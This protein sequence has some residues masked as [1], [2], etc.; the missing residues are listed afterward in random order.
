LL[1]N[2]TNKLASYEVQ[3]A[4]KLFIIDGSGCLYWPDQSLLIFSDTHFEKGSYLAK[5]GNPLP[6]YDTHDTLTRMQKLIETYQPNK[7][8]CLGD[9]MH[10]AYALERI[11][12]SDFQLLEK[13]CCSVSEWEWIIG[14]H[15]KGDHTQSALKD[16]QFSQELLIDGVI[17]SHHHIENVSYQI[18][19]HYHPKITVKIK[20]SRVSDKCLIITPSKIIMPSFGTYTG[21]LD[22]HH[23]ALQDVIADEPAKYFLIHKKNVW[24]VK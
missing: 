1:N 6:L 20:E 16:M 22:I 8:I 10:D 14:N 21:G 11:S 19:G 7:V 24:R 3:F 2:D 15:D 12:S 4:N 9:N 5:S 17:F 18:F 23:E 13:I